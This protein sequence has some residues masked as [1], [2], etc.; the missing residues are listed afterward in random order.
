MTNL[1]IKVSERPVSVTYGHFELASS[2][3]GRLQSQRGLQTR[4]CDLRGPSADAILI[5][6]SLSYFPIILRPGFTRNPLMG[7]KSEA[8]QTAPAYVL[9]VIP[10]PGA[11]LLTLHLNDIEKSLRGLMSEFKGSFGLCND[12]FHAGWSLRE[13]DRANGILEDRP[14]LEV[15]M[16][17]K[18]GYYRYTAKPLKDVDISEACSCW[19]HC[20]R[21]SL[22][23]PRIH[24]HDL[25]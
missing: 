2:R 9:L 23:V 10:P 18:T 4:K 25:S 16:G 15:P 6:R 20:D 13:A 11:T 3:C 7:T 22:T 5:F 17:R 19:I 12:N 24:S 8:G 1:C 21:Q 14:K